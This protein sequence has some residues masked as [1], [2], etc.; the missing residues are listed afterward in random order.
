MVSG[1][2]VRRIPCSLFV[3]FRSNLHS[4]CTKVEMVVLVSPFVT[5]AIARLLASTDH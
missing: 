4:A 1:S 5:S 3:V 2:W